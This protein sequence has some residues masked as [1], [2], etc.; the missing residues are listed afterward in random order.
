M[1]RWV[2]ADEKS[3]KS[4]PGTSSGNN[5]ETLESTF[6]DVCLEGP[7]VVCV[8]VVACVTWSVAGLL[9]G[10]GIVLRIVMIGWR[11]KQYIETLLLSSV[12]VES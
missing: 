12:H 10:L 7:G 6:E 2:L 5:G 11:P 8:G 1:P 3:N 4:V 9:I